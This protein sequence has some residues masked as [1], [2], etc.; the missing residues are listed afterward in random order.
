M[1]SFVVFIAV[2]L[3]LSVYPAV[4]RDDHGRREAEALQRRQGPG[5]RVPLQGTGGGG[6][7]RRGRAHRRHSR[8]ECRTSRTGEVL[9]PPVPRARAICSEKE[10]T[11]VLASRKS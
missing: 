7:I 6:R 1:C 4:L 10:S 9:A 8:W 11:R 5:G 3:P 2:I